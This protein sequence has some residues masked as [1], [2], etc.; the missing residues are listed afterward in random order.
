MVEIFENYRS[1][2]KSVTLFKDHN[3]NTDINWVN[4]DARLFQMFDI[5]DNDD[6]IS[7][8]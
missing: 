5:N 7:L 8:K 4:I 3:M 1:H 6:I 2:M